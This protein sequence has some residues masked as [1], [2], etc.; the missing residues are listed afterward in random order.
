MCE[1]NN[2]SLDRR[3]FGVSFGHLG[4][5]FIYLIFACS[6]VICTNSLFTACIHLFSFAAIIIIH[7]IIAL[8]TVTGSLVSFATHTELDCISTKCE[9]EKIEKK[10]NKRYISIFGTQK[11]LKILFVDQW[12]SLCVFARRTKCL[13]LFLVWLGER[14]KNF[15][16]KNLVDV[17]SSTVTWRM[18]A[19]QRCTSFSTRDSCHLKIEYRVT[20]RRADWSTMTTLCRLL[21][22]MCFSWHIVSSVFEVGEEKQHGV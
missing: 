10:K 21:F 4:S 11:R 17:D 6:A 5:L 20:F 19:I 14:N 7:T 18:K 1:N 22:T 15:V 16:A 12:L 3:W 13:S 8:S 2:Y 9:I